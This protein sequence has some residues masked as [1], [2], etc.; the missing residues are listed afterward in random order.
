MN[1]FFLKFDDPK[2]EREYRQMVA[3]NSKRYSQIVM[4][5]LLVLAVIYTFGDK[6]GGSADSKLM[7][8]RLILC[9]VFFGAS[10]LQFTR[11]FERNYENV[12]IMVFLPLVF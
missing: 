3:K 2:T 8:E 10:L 5:L 12:V 1:K 4:G 6:L 9:A 7:W 11:Y